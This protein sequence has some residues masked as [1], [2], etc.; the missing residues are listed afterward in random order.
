ME[1]TD[2]PLVPFS[3]KKA[4]LE[5]FIQLMT[6]PEHRLDH[7]TLIQGESMKF[8]RKAFKELT[9]SK[10]AAQIPLSVDQS[11]NKDGR[12][13]VLYKRK[14]IAILG[15]DS[16]GRMTKKI[17]ETLFTPE[18]LAK[19]V[20]DPKKIP[21]ES[22]RQPADDERFELHKRAVQIALGQA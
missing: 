9:G 21:L 15:G 4:A 3:L 5:Q 18:E 11:S 14:N 7:A 12:E 20:L 10:N 19:V 2:F 8:T 16:P 1:T 17:A 22:E 13:E 6:T